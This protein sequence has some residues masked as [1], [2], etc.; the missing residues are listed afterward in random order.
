MSKSTGT[1]IPSAK[2]RFGALREEHTVISSYRLGQECQP[3]SWDPPEDGLFEPRN[4]LI[5]SNGR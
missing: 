3:F 1:R 2:G 4:I 5:A